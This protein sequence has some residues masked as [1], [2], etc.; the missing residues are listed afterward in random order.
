MAGSA[1]PTS[2][3]RQREMEQ[4]DRVNE[5]AARRAERKARSA[6]RTANGQAGPEIGEAPILAFDAE[7]PAIAV[8]PVAPRSRPVPKLYVGNIAFSADAG[9]LR[10]LF[11]TVGEVADVLVVTDRDTG[12]PRGFAFVT[13]AT[14][15]GTRRAMSELDG[16]TLENRQLRV[17]EAEDRRGPGRR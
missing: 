10:E 12:R 14:L 9:A 7:M 1:R 3:K 17:S 16:A 11:A 13:M 8:A 6:E 15:E 5:R 2:N 4:K